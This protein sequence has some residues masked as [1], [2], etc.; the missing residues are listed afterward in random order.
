MLRELRLN[1]LMLALL[2]AFTIL[3]LVLVVTTSARLH[4]HVSQSVNSA[5]QM[6]N[7]L[8][9]SADYALMSNQPALL[10]RSL[11]RLL[12]QPGV[13]EIR[14]L[15]QAGDVW[16][17]LRQ[18]DRHH[19]TDQLH[20]Y[21]ALIEHPQPAQVA[22][23]WLSP[24]ASQPP[25]GD[26]L[27]K[28]EIGFDPDMVWQRELSTFFQSLLIGFAALIIVGIVASLAARRLGERF[29]SIQADEARQRRI[30]RELMRD[31][32]Q[33]WQ[34]E[35]ARQQAWGKWSHDIRTPLH[36]VSGMLEL[37]D[38][39]VLDDEQRDY[40]L[41]ARAAA[42]A[43]EESLRGTPLPPQT[44][45]D[46]ASEDSPDVAAAR[47][48]GKRILLIED[49]PISQHLLRGIFEP[50]GVELVCVGT[51]QQALAH[52]HEAWDLVMVDGELPDMNAAYLARA[53]RAA[54]AAGV[55]L[56]DNGED[57][58][59]RFAARRAR[60][61]MVAITAHAD[62]VRLARYKAAGLEPVLNKPLRRSHLLSV[63]TP[64]IS[65]SDP[66]T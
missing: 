38:T 22:D 54:E 35:H 55:R 32:E 39:T 21:S 57:A 11:Q 33:R 52:R 17:E 19:S 28:V 16:I 13:R 12:L 50:W 62:P 2:P 20:H 44:D 5:H 65:P 7:Q 46:A 51:G 49:D 9:A 23:D 56:D 48:R 30:S 66:G 34:D 47:W 24:D 18:L 14:I 36:G 26:I 25:S 45:R 10:D 31:R 43:M 4:D 64:L 1:L 15:D 60:V 29:A 53:W 8:A 61:P 40:V 59:L 27:G 41:K 42:R 37:L 58:P 3:L 6:T 63:L